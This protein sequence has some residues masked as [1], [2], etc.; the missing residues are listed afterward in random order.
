M[1]PANIGPKSTVIES[2]ESSGLGT[3]RDLKRILD[4]SQKIMDKG[5][6]VECAENEN[7]S[8]TKKVWLSHAKTTAAQLHAVEKE[9]DYYKAQAL[10]YMRMQ[11]MQ[12][13][14]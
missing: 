10:K 4:E 8:P 3:D 2:N 11:F 14:R 1:L 5:F 13:W 12:L 6:L 7:E 9:R